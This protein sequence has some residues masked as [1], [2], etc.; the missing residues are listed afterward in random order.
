MSLSKAKRRNT[1]GYDKT[2]R[3][4]K[5]IGTPITA[6]RFQAKQAFWN[7][8]K[9]RLQDHLQQAGKGAAIE[10]A[11]T[12]GLDPSD[13]H[14]F[15][16][17]ACEHDREPSFSIGMMILMYLSAYKYKATSLQAADFY[18]PVERPC[19]EDE[20]LQAILDSHYNPLNTPKPKVKI[21]IDST[22]LVFTL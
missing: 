14:M 20:V 5:G 21:Q 6:A 2:G 22:N 12:T 15:T 13:I 16:C 11:R 7:V 4:R 3:K 19:V 1:I 18:S 10:M 8:L 17:P 9:K